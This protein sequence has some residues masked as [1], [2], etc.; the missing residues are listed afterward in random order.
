MPSY[1]YTNMK[2]GRSIEKVYPIGRAP[3]RV[4]CDG[5]AY[6]RDLAAEHA[7]FRDTPGAWPMRSLAM[8]CHPSQRQKMMDLYSRSGVNTYIDDRGFP[9]IQSRKHR[10]ELMRVH[11]LFDMDAGYGDRAPKNL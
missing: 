2:T 4:V 7:S 1:V 10:N 5:M 11:G 9:I 6:V 8:R 3:R